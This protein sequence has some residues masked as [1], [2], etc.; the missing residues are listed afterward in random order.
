LFS[1][2]CRIVGALQNA[3]SQDVASGGKVNKI[4]WLDGGC[5][6]STFLPLPSDYKEEYL[7][8]LTASMKEIHEMYTENSGRLTQ[9]AVQAQTSNSRTSSQVSAK[10]KSGSQA[11]KLTTSRVLEQ[12]KLFETL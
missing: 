5:I 6:F 12:I 1:N 8:I 2:S 4:E 7:E 3:Y 11:T 10:N 9:M